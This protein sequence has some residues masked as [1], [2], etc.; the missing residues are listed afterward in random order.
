MKLI[1]LLASFLGSL[2]LAAPAN[3]NGDLGLGVMLGNTTSITGKYWTEKDRGWD[4][5]GGGSEEKEGWLQASYIKHYIGAFGAETRFIGETTPYAGVGLG[6]GFN[7]TTDDIK[8]RND[9]FARLPLGL[10]WMPNRTPVDLFA[11]A[12]PTYMFSPEGV[13]YL[14]G[15]VGGRYYF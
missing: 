11:E 12:T 10:S 5:A 3:R 9:Y 2:S 1:I 14:S 6:M 15:N 13:L 8:Y 7:R 4:I